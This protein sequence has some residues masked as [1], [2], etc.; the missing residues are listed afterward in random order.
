MT[1]AIRRRFP[2]SQNEWARFDGPAGTQM[3]DAAIRA[4]SDWSSSGNNANTHGAFA[5]AHATDALL[6]RARG[7]VAQLLDTDPNGVVF[8][9]NMTTMTFALTRAIARTLKPG[10]RV[11]GTRL[12]HDANVSPWRIACEESGAEHVLAPFSPIDG[13]LDMDAMAKLITPNTKWVAVTGASNLIGTMPDIKTVVALARHVGARVFVD[14][15]HLVPHMPVSVR[16]IGCDVLATSPY[17][18]Y[19]PHAGVLCIE[20]NLLNALPVAKVRPADD[21]GP[22]RFETGTPNLENIAATEAAARHLLEE[23][24][25]SVAKYERDVFAPL[26][27]GLLGMSHVKVWGPPTLE[28]R[29]PTV[30]F[31]VNGL[32]PDRVAEVLAAKKIAVWAG[33][34]YAVELVSH[35]GLAESGGVVRAGVVRYVTPDDVQRLLAAVAAL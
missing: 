25:A 20:P 35:L 23:N 24:M 2:G 9:A 16:D 21:V 6:E 1:D 4:A 10:D 11:V 33:S 3:V 19:G 26:L 15:V 22:R 14:A 8:G 32:T 12:D 17:K 18:W 29:T 5:A 30:A 13:R 7:V 27:H 34:S 31:T 28:A